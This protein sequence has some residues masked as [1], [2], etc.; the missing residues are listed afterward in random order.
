VAAAAAEP[1]HES[2][3]LRCP[4]CGVSAADLDHIA[5]CAACG[6]GFDIEDGIVHALAPERAAYYARFLEEY[7]A[8]RNQEGRGAADPE[9]Y[10]ALPYRD[11]T[12]RNSGQWRIRARSYDY[13]ARRVLPRLAAGRRLDV[14]DLGAGNGWMSYRLALA[15]HRPV[16]VD[17]S[18]DAR[19]GLG[20]ARHYLN[21]SG[22]RFARFQAELERLPFEGGQFDLAVFNSSFHYATSYDRVLAE[23]RRCLKASG[24]VVILDT[25]IYRRFEHG[26]RMRE[27][28]HRDFAARYGFRSD[29]VPSIEFLDRAM[30]EDLS[31]RL[32][33]TFRMHRPWYG[34]RWHA[35][36]LAA[37]LRGRRPPSRF[38]LLVGT[39]DRP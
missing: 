34:L 6:F 2:I 1:I 13:F 15:G 14:L 35:R 25:P 37:R 21:G 4:A 26:A 33:I 20:A 28:R 8:I 24:A 29:A 30:I 16:A 10:L 9:F 27:E 11:R 5:P 36:P 3:A 7:A 23:A 32:S 38:A 39:W 31:R 17:I 12:G 18:T 19:D 22:V